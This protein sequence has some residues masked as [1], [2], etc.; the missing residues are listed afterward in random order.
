MTLPRILFWFKYYL[1]TVDLVPEMSLLTIPLRY[2]IFCSF[3]GLIIHTPK[4]VNQSLCSLRNLPG[5]HYICSKHY[6][7]SILLY[8]QCVNK[9]KKLLNIVY[10]NVPVMPLSLGQSWL[11]CSG[12]VKS[13][14]VLYYRSEV[15]NY[16][17]NCV[18]QQFVLNIQVVL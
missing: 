12:T 17:K 3:Q 15:L 5:M 18:T 8:V 14:Y 9:E 10:L 11:R 16:V 2:D 13:N 1:D 6:F 4:F 7:L